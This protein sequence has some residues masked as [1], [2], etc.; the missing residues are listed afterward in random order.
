MLILMQSVF[1]VL[2]YYILIKIEWYKYCGYSHFIEEE[3]ETQKVVQPA[4]GYQVE[5]F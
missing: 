4:Q 5:D 1:H 2:I 3:A